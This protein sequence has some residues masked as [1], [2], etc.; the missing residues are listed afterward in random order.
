MNIIEFLSGKKTTIATILGAILVY[1]QGRGYIQE[2]TAILFSAIMVALGL[3]ANVATGM[4]YKRVGG[5][6]Y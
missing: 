4:Y 2:D 1:V 3:T 5:R 6:K